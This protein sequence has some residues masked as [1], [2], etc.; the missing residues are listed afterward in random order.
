[1]HRATHV[2]P[3]QTRNNAEKVLHSNTTHVLLNYA[4]VTT[5]FETTSPRVHKLTR[6]I[7][8]TQHAGSRKTGGSSSK[9]MPLPHGVHYSRAKCT[10]LAAGS[11]YSLQNT[12]AIGLQCTWLTP[13]CRI[14]LTLRVQWAIR[15]LLWNFVFVQ[16]DNEHRS[17]WNV[18]R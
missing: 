15:A 18:I 8:P 11:S 12:D 9:T 10:P 1:M 4:D 5:V 16:D 7:R 14:G 2:L 6:N 13:D 3:E 17:V